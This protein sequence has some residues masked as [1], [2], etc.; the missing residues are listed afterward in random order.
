MM[1][2]YKTLKCGIEESNLGVHELLWQESITLQ[3]F[4][5]VSA[6]CYHGNRLGFY[7][8]WLMHEIHEAAL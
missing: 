1:L 5:P 8:F 3:Q 4:Y 6:Y 7:V 2:L